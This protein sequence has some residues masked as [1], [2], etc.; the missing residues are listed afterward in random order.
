[1]I[2]GAKSTVTAATGLGASTEQ[3]FWRLGKAPDGHSLA[4]VI[5]QMFYNVKSGLGLDRGC[6]SGSLDNG[7]MQAIKAD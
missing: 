6:Q 3:A 4:S 7:F 5:E 2:S 1:M